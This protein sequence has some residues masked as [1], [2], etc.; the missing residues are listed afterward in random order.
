MLYQQGDLLI[1]SI[2]NIPTGATKKEKTEK[3]Y[4]LAE[5]EHTGHTHRILAGVL[6]YCIGAKLFL[7]NQ[8]EVTILHE[9]HN[10]VTLPPGMWEIDQ[11]REYDHFEEEA[12]VILD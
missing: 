2:Q 7:E 8:K 10:E 11:V 9:E 3:G 1:K 4:I 6:M 5:G 12:R